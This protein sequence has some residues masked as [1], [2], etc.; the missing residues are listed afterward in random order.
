ML[1]DRCANIKAGKWDA[2]MA[3]PQHTPLG[4]GYNKSLAY[5]FHQ[6]DYWS[7]FAEPQVRR[8]AAR[9]E[10]ATVARG[11]AVRQWTW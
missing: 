1:M 5:F 6:T 7:Y 9:L 2:G 8:V 11:S 3:T 10:R 4:R